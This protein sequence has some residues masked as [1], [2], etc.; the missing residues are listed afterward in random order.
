M[1]LNYLVDLAWNVQFSHHLILL[2]I[3][4][5]LR[6]LSG[7]ETLFIGTLLIGFAIA[8]GNVL[9]PAIIKKNFIHRIGL[10][11]GVY[12]VSMNL[13]SAIASGVSV[14]IA[15]IS[16]L[17]W[18][19][20]LGIFGML[21]IAA[22][23][24]WIPQIRHQQNFVKMPSEA[25]KKSSQLW[26]SPLAWKI[27]L[28]MGL[29]SLIYYA[30]IAWFPE[31]LQQQGLTRF[32]SWMDDFTHAIF[33]FAI[34]IYR[35][36]YC[37]TNGKS[38]LVGCCYEPYYSRSEYAAY[39]SETLFLFRL[40]IIFIGIACGFSFSLAMMFFEFRT[41]SVDEAAE[42]SGM[43]QSFGY[44]LAAFG[45]LVFGLLRDVTE[46]WTTPLVMLI[47]ASVIFVY[48]WYGSGKE[49]ICLGRKIVVPI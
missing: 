47:V 8:I 14:P 3:G 45:P 9:L 5:G 18:Q 38:T 23:L 34:Y 12:A 2:T 36:D 35:S 37:W 11:T 42:I 31:I 26:R 21:S 13:S 17:G 27:T 20:A 32:G 6:S 22:I 40:W 46:S 7:I 16:W 49:R 30:V 25:K 43:A 33:N 24:F 1:R 28:F 48:L 41:E 10:M 29:Q 4:I 19:G 39:Y 44:L 15:S